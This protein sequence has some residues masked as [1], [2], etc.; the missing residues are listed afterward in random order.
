MSERR[1]RI[2][3]VGSYV[4]PRVV[5]NDDLAQMIDTSDEW[6]QQRSGIRT[7]YWVEGETSTTDLALEAS[8]EALTMA[9]CEPGD[10]EMIIFAT[11][12]PDRR[13]QVV[14]ITWLFGSFI[15]GASGFGTPAAITAPLPTVTPSVTMAPAPI[16]TSSSISIP[17]HVTP[18]LNMGRSSR[19]NMWLAATITA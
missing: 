6:I 15:E 13:I 2:V 19:R 9:D 1:T 8:R 7:R 18:C 17:S 5:T 3:G 11:I 4:P 14:L 16:Q 12:S 10:L